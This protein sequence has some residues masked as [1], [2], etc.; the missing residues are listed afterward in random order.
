MP[1]I[2]DTFGGPRGDVPGGLPSSRVGLAET[3]PRILA[4]GNFQPASANWNATAIWLPSGVKVTGITFFSGATGLGTGTHQWFGIWDNALALWAGS[5]DDTSTAWA[6]HTAKRL[7][8]TT[9]KTT[10]Y[11]GLYYVGIE[12]SVSAGN[13]P[14][15]AA[16]GTA[17]GSGALRGLTPAATILDTSTADTAL[18]PTLTQA[19]TTTGSGGYFYAV[20]D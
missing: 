2:F 6:A 17:V 16:L 14:S 12:V 13:V 9:A 8:L 18:A 11:A 1:N 15:F 7:T 10:T 19:A 3:F 5:A 20:L 4:A